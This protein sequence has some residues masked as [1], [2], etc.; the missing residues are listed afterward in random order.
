MRQQINLYQP[1]S[2]REHKQVSATSMALT[3][4]VV[5][6]A[7][8]AF[9]VHETLGVH[10]L[11]REVQVL[12]EQQTRQQAQLVTAGQLQSTR[13]N[14]ADIE[15]RVKALTTTLGERTNALRVLQSGGAGQTIGFAARMEA[16]ARRHVDGLWI[17]ALVMSGTNGSMSL[18]GGTVD[19]NIVAAYLRSLSSESVLSGTRFDDFIIERPSVAAAEASGQQP[20]AERAGKP[21]TIDYVRFHAGSKSLAAKQLEAAT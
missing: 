14:A 13:A 11:E 7:L 18:S 12:R 19:A 9:S 21:L 16:L 15:A 4:G 17:D 1:I 20:L 5:A 3:L 10:R 8:G 2:S 6:V